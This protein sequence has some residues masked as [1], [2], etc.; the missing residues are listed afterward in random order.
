MTASD[1]RRLEKAAKRAFKG[2]DDDAD[3]TRLPGPRRTFVVVYTIQGVI[4]NGGFQYLF[5]RD[6]PGCPAY[7]EFS[8]AYREIGATDVAEWLDRAVALFPFSDPHLRR[9]DRVRYLREHCVAGD[10]PMG[11][12]SWEAIE[13]GDRVDEFLLK[14][15]LGVPEFGI[16]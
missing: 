8:R 3:V 7:G 6:W 10:S 14:F 2:L 5:E 15:A 4:G 12:L 1:E 11:V 16:A 9:E 13:A